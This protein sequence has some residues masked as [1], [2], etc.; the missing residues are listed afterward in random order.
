MGWLYTRRTQPAETKHTGKSANAQHVPHQAS[1]TVG[2]DQA[3]AFSGSA[4]PYRPDEDISAEAVRLRQ[5]LRDVLLTDYGLLSSPG[6]KYPHD[7]Y[8]HYAAVIYDRQNLA[9]APSRN[10]DTLA[11]RAMNLSR[12]SSHL[13]LARHVYGPAS[14]LGIGEELM[15]TTL[16]RYLHFAD[17]VERTYTSSIPGSS[18][19]KVSSDYKQTSSPTTHKF[20]GSEALR[21][22]IVWDR[23][24]IVPA[25]FEEQ[26]VRHQFELATNS[27]VTQ[28]FPSGHLL[29]QRIE[30]EAK[31]LEK[32][33][34]PAEQQ[35]DHETQQQATSD[36]RIDTPEY[37]RWLA[38]FSRTS[39]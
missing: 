8:Y 11:S 15:D 12:S 34:V 37:V 22:K 39:T 9:R 6:S 13:I 33:P 23:S 38:W 36:T 28:H 4:K 25:V 24:E 18:T 26:M 1:D 17:P 3:R 32:D 30:A 16:I 5:F 27:L 35:K 29:R 2:E 10:R 21:T 20:Q 31:T 7:E 14:E 19:E